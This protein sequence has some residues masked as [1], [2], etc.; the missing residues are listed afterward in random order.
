MN[1]LISVSA[2]CVNK[3][4][5]CVDRLISVSKTCVNKSEQCVDWLFSVSK[6]A[7]ISL[8]SVWTG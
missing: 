5:Q 4:E 8:S 6:R 7:L 1:R 2:T 3:S